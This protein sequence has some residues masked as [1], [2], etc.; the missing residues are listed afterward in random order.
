MNG[1][2]CLRKT[3]LLIHEKGLITPLEQM[4]GCIMPGVEI[5]G[6]GRVKG[7][8]EQGEIGLP[9][10]NEQMR[11]MGQQTVSMNFKLIA[12]LMMAQQGEE[13]AAVLVGAKKILTVIPRQLDVIAGT[14][15]LNPPGSSHRGE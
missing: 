11:I 2:A 14:W 4:A 8:H 3:L 9:G 15:I 1:A 5:F 7:L 12:P 13:L 6:V 10:L